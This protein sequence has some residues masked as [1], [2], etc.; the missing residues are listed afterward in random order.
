MQQLTTIV[1][2]DNL[3]FKL[4]ERIFDWKESFKSVQNL[5]VRQTEL[6]FSSQLFVIVLALLNNGETWKKQ[7]KQK[8][9]WIYITTSQLWIRCWKL[10]LVTEIRVIFSNYFTLYVYISMLWLY[11]ERKISLRIN[12]YVCW[13]CTCLTYGVQGKYSEGLFIWIL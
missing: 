8:K 10:F 3:I 4:N 13:V 2:V 1:F 9:Y 5:N 11:F 6:S 12:Q 7:K